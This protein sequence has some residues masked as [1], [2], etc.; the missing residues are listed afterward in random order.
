V[1]RRFKTG[2]MLRLDG[3]TGELQRVRQGHAGAG[4]GGP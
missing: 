2:D 1:T 3:N 4:A